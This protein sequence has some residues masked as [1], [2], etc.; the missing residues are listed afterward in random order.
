M[1][2]PDKKQFKKIIKIS[3]LALGGLFVLFLLGYFAV[4]RPLA[5][6]EEKKDF[7]AAERELDAL[8][9][10]IVATIGEPSRTEKKNSCGYSSAKFEGGRL[11]CGSNFAITY[12]AQDETEANVMYEKVMYLLSKSPGIHTLGTLKSNP[13][14]K[15]SHSY[16]PQ[17]ITVEMEGEPSDIRCATYVEYGNSGG[18]ITLSSP[19][20]Q[21]LA[22]AIS[23][24]GQALVGHFPVEK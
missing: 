7:L 14:T 11:G 6:R 3:S 23:C 10:K 8:Q 19:A 17:S 9:A 24:R 13:Y 21:S 18:G 5:I 2:L 1:T 20:K 12:P 22:I 15:T 16:N 4:Y